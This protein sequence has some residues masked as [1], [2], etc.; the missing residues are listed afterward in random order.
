MRIPVP[1]TLVGPAMSLFLASRHGPRTSQQT[2][3]SHGIPFQTRLYASTASICTENTN[4]TTLQEVD[5]PP[6]IP[7]PCEFDDPVQLSVV[8]SWV[9]DVMSKCWG[10]IENVKPIF[11]DYGMGYTQVA[12]CVSKEQENIYVIFRGTDVMEFPDILSNIDIVWD[13]YGPPKSSILDNDDDQQQAAA[14]GPKVDVPGKVQRGWN[15]KIFNPKLHLPLSEKLL[16]IKEQYPTYKVIVAGHSLGAALSI[17]YGVYVAKYVLPQ[18]LV[19]VINLGSP[20]V[21]DETFYH[22]IQEISN[23]NIWRMVYQDDVVAR[24]PPMWL[25]YR[26]VGHLLHWDKHDEIKAY[27]QQLETCMDSECYAGIPVDEWNVLFGKIGDH[28]HKHYKCVVK[29]ARADPDKYW[30]KGFELLRKRDDK[31]TDVA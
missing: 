11:Y 20:R 22:A 14:R 31:N 13:N 29:Q 23:L 21:G 18:D 19:E 6:R 15:R 7:D 16:Q 4:S 9:E 2:I 25:G 27:H 3:I 28:E 8:V 10:E 1:P 24:L 26:H 30:P 5:P 17:L 12:I